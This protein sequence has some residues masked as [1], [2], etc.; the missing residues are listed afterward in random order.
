MSNAATGLW[1]AVGALLGGIAG[2]ATA[3]Y[4][5]QTRPRGRATGSEVEDA[6]VVGGATGAVLGAFVAGAAMG[7]QALRPRLTSG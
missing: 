6:M 4:A 1:S 2:A 5:V 7:E 3:K